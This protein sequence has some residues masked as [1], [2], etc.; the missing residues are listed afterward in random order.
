MRKRQLIWFS[1]FFILLLLVLS[2]VR[3]DRQGR[4]SDVVE[5]T[6]TLS[7]HRPLSLVNQEKWAD[8]DRWYE[9]LQAQANWYASLPKPKPLPTPPKTSGTVSAT[10][11]EAPEGDC[12]PHTMS[13]SEAHQCWDGLLA[14]AHKDDQGNCD[15]Y[16]DVN[17]AFHVMYCE[18]KGKYD[19]YNPSGATGLFQ[20]IGGPVDP[21]ANVNQAYQMWLKR[22]WGPWVCQ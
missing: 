5:E 7:Y 12:G 16:W 8:E 18:S 19:A 13:V 1:A 17:K 6:P 10:A 3:A 20:I 9:S 14:C 21:T 15:S 11:V 2:P 4:N 22:D